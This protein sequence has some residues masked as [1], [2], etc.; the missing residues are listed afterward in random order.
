MQDP[1]LDVWGL[2]GQNGALAR[3]E[4]P[5]AQALVAVCVGL[6]LHFESPITEA[7]ATPD[8]FQ[9]RSAVRKKKPKDA[10]GL[11]WST[12]SLS[13]TGGHFQP[14]RSVIGLGR[15]NLTVPAHKEGHGSLTASACCSAVP[16]T[17][18]RDSCRVT[19]RIPQLHG[20]E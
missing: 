8:P 19:E 15:Y 10:I 11:G 13:V 1:F 20:K 18:S 5:A 4:S 14:G 16:A 7:D 9:D 12:S 2:G 6:T 3:K 17:Y